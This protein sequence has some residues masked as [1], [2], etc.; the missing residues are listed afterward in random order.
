MKLE[1]GADAG[2]LAGDRAEVGVAAERPGVVVAPGAD[3]QE[4]WTWRL[5]LYE[6]LV[7]VDDGPR[8]AFEPTDRRERG[9]VRELGN[10]LVHRQ[11]GLTPEVVVVWVVEEVLERDVFVLGR[12]RQR[13]LPAA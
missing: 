8:V 13:R 4:V 5:L 9:H 12:E 7:G 11:A 6:H 2:D 3:E 1:V 10:V